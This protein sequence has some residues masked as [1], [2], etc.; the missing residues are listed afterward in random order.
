MNAPDF[1]PP[2]PPELRVQLEA[3]RAAFPRYSVNLV[4]KG[5]KARFEAVSKNA[6]NPWCLISEDARKIWRELRG[7]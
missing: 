3:L 1:E 6:G 7:Q 5:G 2:P 4:M